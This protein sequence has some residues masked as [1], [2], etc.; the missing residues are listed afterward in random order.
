MNKRDNSLIYGSAILLILVALAAR[1]DE[2]P[3]LFHGFLD[4]YYAW[5][6]NQP[7]NHQN[8]EPGTGTSAAR[9]NEFEINLAAVTIDRDPAPVGF[10]F[11]LVAGNGTDIV[12][13]ADPARDTFRYIYQASLSYKATNKLTLEGGI[14]PSHIG[15]ESFY[16]KDNWNYTRGWLGE[17]S[18]YYQA[19]VKATYA[20]NDTWS[21]QIHVLNGWQIIGE[22][23]DAKAAG[24]Q[25]AYSGPRLSASFNT[26]VG[27][28]L[29]N[30]NKDLRLF[31]DLVATYKATPKFS[32]AGSLD[33]GRQQLPELADANWLGASLW[34]RYAF[35]DRHAVAAR[36][37]RFRDPDNA[38]SG[39]AQTVGSATL[40]YE[41]HPANNL[42]V[43]TEARRDHSTAAVF[44]KSHGATAKDENLL[45]IGV[46][47]TF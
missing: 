5:N 39:A 4:G 10:H 44:A 42:I 21:A 17:F 20:F 8:F 38:I 34:G 9:A 1:A 15:F 37:D 18:P 25:I 28:E 16:S 41:F 33:R 7:A 24:T 3:V 30:D 6:S 19:G 29:P 23:N 32:V 46:V 43:K 35:D 12:H 31:G 14:Y 11:S 22:N 2:P 47:A 45:I 27:A 36:V 26:F 40:T 13:A